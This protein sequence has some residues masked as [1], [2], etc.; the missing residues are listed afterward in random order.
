MGFEDKKMQRQRHKRS[1]R[2]VNFTAFF[3]SSVLASC[4][5]FLGMTNDFIS[6]MGHSQIRQLG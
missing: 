5:L 2:F 4:Y 1:K 6:V 3:F